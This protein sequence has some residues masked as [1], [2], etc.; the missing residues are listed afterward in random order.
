MFVIQ[1]K[2]NQ[3]IRIGPV[4]ITITK[5]GDS[6]VKLGINAPRNIRVKRSEDKRDSNEV[7]DDMIGKDG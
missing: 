3:S 1:R 6:W 7:E 2:L 5:I 4:E